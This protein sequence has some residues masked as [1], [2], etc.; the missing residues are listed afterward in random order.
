M[1][2]HRIHSLAQRRAS[3]AR[4]PGGGVER[5]RR[6]N[7][8]ALVA[9]HTPPVHRVVGEARAACKRLLHEAGEVV[10]TRS[11]EH[12]SAGVGRV[13]LER[14]PPHHLEHDQ[15]RPRRRPPGG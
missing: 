7:V 4:V 1:K 6:A 14:V 5:E 9:H 3:A 13:E 12:F 2:N 10:R 15:A 8:V 11:G